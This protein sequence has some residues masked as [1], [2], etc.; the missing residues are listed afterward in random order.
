LLDVLDNGLP[1]FGVIAELP[2]P[3]QLVLQ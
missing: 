3:H 2:M 1:R